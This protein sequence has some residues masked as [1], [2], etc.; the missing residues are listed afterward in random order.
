MLVKTEYYIK[1]MAMKKSYLTVLLVFLAAAVFSQNEMNDIENLKRIADGIIENNHRGFVNKKTGEVYGS[2]KGLKPGLDLQLLST[3]S[4]FYY[5]EGVINIAMLDLGELLNDP[6]YTDYSLRNIEFIYAN[7]PYFKDLLT[8]DNHWELP[9]ASFYEITYLDDCGAMAASI[10][11]VYNINKNKEY[12]GYIN[13]TADFILTKQFRLDDGT[14]VRDDPIKYA[15]WADDLY[16]SVPFLARMGALTG[17]MKYFD[18]AAKQVIQFTN[19]LWDDRTGLYFH[20]WMSDD[21][22]PG[23]A[24]WG[25][26]NG[27]VMM[28]QV[29]L[30]KLLP[31]DHPKR[32]QLLEIF[33]RQIRNVARYQSKSGLWHQ[34]LDK[35]D[36][37]LETSCTAMFTYGTAWAVNEKILPERYIT[38]AQQGWKAIV[39]KTDKDYRSSAVNDICI[40]TGIGNDLNHYYTRPKRANS[41]GLGAVISAGVEI[42]RYDKNKNAEK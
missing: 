7:A 10:I 28:A 26:A 15:L 41:V 1:R 4:S 23:V 32:Q 24:H 39:G 37:Y 29:E 33:K 9:F 3:H 35:E 25:R 2:V 34:L 16:M 40:G 18:D 42:V 17:D 27:W 30:L 31:K 19:Y 6:K 14:L 12:M 38:I 8:E 22:K 21:G 36:S 11:D 5:A 13:E 20:N